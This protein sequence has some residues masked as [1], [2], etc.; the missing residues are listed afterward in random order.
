MLTRP[1]LGML[2]CGWFACMGLAA[3]PAMRHQYTPGIATDA[4]GWPAASQLQRAAAGPTL[5]L[6][7]HAR[8][9]CAG[10]SRDERSLAL[11]Q[12]PPLRACVLVVTPPGV[13]PDAALAQRARRLPRAE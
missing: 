1:G 11:A 4:G 6:V 9:P 2:I 3:A 7:A 5:V 12:A 8:C 13:P 10:A